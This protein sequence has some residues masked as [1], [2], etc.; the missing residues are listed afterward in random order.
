LEKNIVEVQKALESI[1]FLG[2]IHHMSFLHQLH[3]TK[4]FEFGSEQKKNISRQVE[5]KNV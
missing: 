5:N 1:Q 4:E 3:R 2:L